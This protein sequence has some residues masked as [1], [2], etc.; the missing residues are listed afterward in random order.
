M[1]HARPESRS[2]RWL[3]NGKPDALVAPTDRGLLYGDGLFETIAFH[4]GRSALWSLHMAR[5]GDGCRRLGL[6][7][8]DVDLLAA[9]CREL[10]G[11]GN[12][13][14]I[15]IAITRG[16]GGRAYFPPETA[17]PTRILMRRE[18][19]NDM[20]LQR[21]SGLPMHTSALR[22]D[23]NVLGGLKHMNRLEQV[24][25]AEECARHGAGE[26]LVLDSAGLIVEGLAGNIVVVREG[27]LIAPGPHPAAV[28]GVG[29]EWLRRHADSKLIERPFAAAELTR[30][31]ALWVINSVRGP[32]PVCALDG[33]ALVR[34]ERI[35]EWRQRWQK[36]IEE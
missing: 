15:R 3:V 25:I 2:T 18:M 36:E 16:S 24:L 32:C 35:P 26:A 31:D 21:D 33:R 28:A 20:A 12:S 34:D 8:P 5:L 11:G 4:R 9:E 22:L 30:D 13:A 6:P 14:V 19:P 10:L 29:L 23:G 27:R 17:E 7:R 1:T